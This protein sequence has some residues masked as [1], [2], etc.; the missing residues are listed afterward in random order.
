MLANYLKGIKQNVV[1]C[2]VKVKSI[3]MGLGRCK[4]IRRSEHDI[5]ISLPI[6][7]MAG[8]FG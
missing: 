1:Y 4:F 8:L 3:A 6:P 5:L 7:Y 2:K